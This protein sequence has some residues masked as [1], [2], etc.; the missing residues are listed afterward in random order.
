MIRNISLIGMPGAG[1]TVVG[2]ALSAHL[3]WNCIDTDRQI[4]DKLGAT[5]QQVL[6]DRGYQALRRLE[7]EHIESLALNSTIIST[8]GSAVYSADGMR[9]LQ[10]ISTI[11]FLDIDLATVEKRIHNFDQRGIASSEGQTLE[12]IFA[13]RYPLYQ[14]YAQI[15]LP[16]AEISA[17]QAAATIAS[18]LGM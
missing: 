5:L 9:H 8:G 7:A 11:V 17:E 6:E 3:G 2:Q 4:E 10:R 18:E 13:D 12:M 14:K 1:K 15:T 16:N